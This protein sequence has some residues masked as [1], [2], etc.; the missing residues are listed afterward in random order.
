MRSV[1]ATPPRWIGRHPRSGRS[2]CGPIRARS[3]SFRFGM[4]RIGGERKPD[5]LSFHSEPS[6]TAGMEG[7]DRRHV[8]N[9]L[10][11]RPERSGSVDCAYN[12]HNARVLNTVPK[13]RLL[14]WRTGE[15]WEPICEALGLPVPSEPFP[16][17][18]RARNSARAQRRTPSSRRKDDIKIRRGEG[19]VLNGRTTQRRAARL[20]RRRRWTVRRIA[21]WNRGR[22]NG[23]GGQWTHRTPWRRAGCRQPVEIER[24][25]PDGNSW[26]NE[27]PNARLRLKTFIEHSAIKR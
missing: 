27:G 16:R 7:H 1:R 8:S 6:R 12:A 26:V 2:S 14:V 11:R 4:Q 18:T 17:S 9:A 15:G 21:G 19:H 3:C 10:G 25:W 22:G 20:S 23:D 5:D 13:E 24:P